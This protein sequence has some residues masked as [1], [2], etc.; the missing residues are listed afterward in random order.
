MARWMGA[1][2]T[3][4]VV[5]RL[6]GIGLWRR[7][8]VPAPA[9]AA[10]IGLMTSVAPHAPLQVNALTLESPA[11]ARITG[12]NAAFAPGLT[13]VVDE[14]GEHKSALLHLLAGEAAPAA[15]SVRW[16]GIDV[17][18]LSAAQRAARIFWRDPREPWPE[19]SP[20][21]WARQQAAHHPGWRGADWQAL[22]PAL[23]L[24]EHRHKEMFRLSSGGRRKVLLAAAL[25]SAAPLTLI[26]EPEAALDRPS[27][28]QLRAALAA[29]ARRCQASGRVIVVAHYEAV[30]D[31]PW[32]Q[33]LRLA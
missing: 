28:R 27:I 26:D 10:T 22:V 1:S 5:N 19:L 23:G 21:Q 6:C 32:A 30:P 20:E 9:P 12:F 15:G 17:A 4:N 14:E 31:V 18:A 16:G 3:R 11:G 25:A 24:D 29:E 8:L 13:L 33:V 7:H 2:A